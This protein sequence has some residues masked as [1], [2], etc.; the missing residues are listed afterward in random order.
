MPGENEEHISGHNRNQGGQNPKEEVF[1]DFRL[2]KS[3]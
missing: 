2:E 3:Q 1:K